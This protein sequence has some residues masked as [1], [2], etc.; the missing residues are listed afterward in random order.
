MPSKSP[1]S[2]SRSASPV[3]PAYEASSSSSSRTLQNEKDDKQAMGYESDE[4]QGW[5]VHLLRND[6]EE[7]GLL[8]LPPSYDSLTKDSQVSWT[9]PRVRAFQC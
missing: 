7:S 9:C 4:E 5:I 2:S 1:R 6:E 8:H 3:V